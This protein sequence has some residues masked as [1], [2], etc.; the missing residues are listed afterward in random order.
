MSGGADEFNRRDF[1]GVD[2]PDRLDID[3]F[4]SENPD[5]L[6]DRMYQSVTL[7]FNSIGERDM[8]D[9]FRDNLERLHQGCKVDTG[10]GM[11]VTYDSYGFALHRR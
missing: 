2:Y 9:P 11:F 8:Y 1:R 10:G 5:R 4:P 7:G 3:Q 6:V